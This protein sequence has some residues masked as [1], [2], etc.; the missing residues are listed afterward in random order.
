MKRKPVMPFWG[1][2]FVFVVII[3]SIIYA[4]W[5]FIMCMEEVTNNFWYCL[6]HAS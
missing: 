2:I 5:Q 4:V 6:Q 1:I 3:L